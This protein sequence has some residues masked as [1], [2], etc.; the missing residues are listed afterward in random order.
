MMANASRNVPDRALL[1]TVPGACED[2]TKA[3]GQKK[4]NKATGKATEY[5]RAIFMTS[6]AKP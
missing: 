5:G 1:F 3:A 2:W 6:V 4:A